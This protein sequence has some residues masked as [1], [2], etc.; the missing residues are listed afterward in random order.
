MADAIVYG[1]HRLEQCYSMKLSNPSK[2]TL[3]GHS[4]AGERTG[5]WIKELKAC[6][7]AGLST[8]QQPKYLFISH[9]HS[10]HA[11]SWP[12]IIGRY[13]P[14]VKGMEK[15]R[16]IYFPASGQRAITGLYYSYLKL[17]DSM[18]PLQTYNLNTLLNIKIVP[19]PVKNFERFE[20]PGMDNMIIEVLPAYHSVDSV[21]YG[22]IK[23]KKKL[24]PEYM[25][26]AKSKK[27]EDREIFFKLK[28]TEDINYIVEQPELVFFSDSTIENL[29]KHVEWQK[30]PVIIVECTGFDD[31]CDVKTSVKR[32]HTHWNQLFPIMKQFNNME[33]IVIHTSM[34]ITNEQL[35][36]YQTMM[37]D[38]N[39]KGY[40]WITKLVIKGKIFPEE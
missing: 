25:E 26:L 5:F 32:Q 24:K 10:D 31:V 16:P 38:E 40:I 4:K 34:G 27:K 30:Y 6:L 1:P 28:E 19:T 33:W 36:K 17:A 11:F 13:F 23:I 15:G 12:C 8:N 35:K 18:K 14:D 3:Q 21:G 22:F 2:W 37:D 39:I 9:T 20:L 29:T 7:D